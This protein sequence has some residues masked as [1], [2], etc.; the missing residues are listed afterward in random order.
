VK[1][2]YERRVDEI[3][4]SFKDKLGAT[5]LLDPSV[6]ADRF[7]VAKVEYGKRVDEILAQYKT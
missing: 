3:L 7:A 4:E 2:Q 6:L 1:Q 5:V